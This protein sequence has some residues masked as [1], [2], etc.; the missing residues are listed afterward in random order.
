MYIETTR[1]DGEFN[2]GACQPT[3]VKKVITSTKSGKA[4]GQ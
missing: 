4:A 1:N 3:E 2:T